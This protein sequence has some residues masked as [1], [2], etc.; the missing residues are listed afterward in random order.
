MRLA[1]RVAAAGLSGSDLGSVGTHAILQGLSSTAGRAAS[2]AQRLV[3][4]AECAGA[5]GEALEKQLSDVV[6]AAPARD[7]VLPS[8]SSQSVNLA[9]HG[10]CSLLTSAFGT[11]P[12]GPSLLDLSEDT[13]RALAPLA[14]SLV[15]LLPGQLFHEWAVCRRQYTCDVL[16]DE[17]TAH[18]TSSKAGFAARNVFGS[19]RV[20]ARPWCCEPPG[21]GD[22]VTL[23]C[24]VRALLGVT[25]PV[26]DAAAASPP[27]T[28]DVCVCVAW[29]KGSALPA[30]V[31]LTVSPPRAGAAPVSTLVLFSELGHSMTNPAVMRAEGTVVTAAVPAEWLCEP[32]A[33]IS[34]AFSGVHDD[35]TLVCAPPRA[36]APSLPPCDRSPSPRPGRGRRGVQ[37]GVSA[38]VGWCGCRGGVCLRHPGVHR[39]LPGLAVP[40]VPAAACGAEA[41]VCPRRHAAP[42]VQHRYSYPRA[43]LRC[44]CLCL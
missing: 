5:D 23:T 6:T 12:V 35:T 20:A 22:P 43:P 13:V 11:S 2:L 9:M 38:G 41:H 15:G 33:T 3:T 31:R 44:L 21:D 24:A 30:A 17:S 4:V 7:C 28:V 32:G 25:A 27:A 37:C 19:G 26:C 36:P 14:S 8:T 40:S 29:A 18:S 1:D 10:L 39:A 34:L 42:R 16:F